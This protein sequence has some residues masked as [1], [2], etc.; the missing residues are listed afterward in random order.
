MEFRNSCSKFVPADARRGEMQSTKSETNDQ[1]QKDNAQNSAN[2]GR[3][4]FEH[5][6]FS[7]GCLF[8][9]S[10][11]VLRVS[12]TLVAGIVTRKPDMPPVAL[13]LFPP[14]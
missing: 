14:C 10:C 9:I 11:F 13:P 6:N 4:R 12:A 3:V 7:F 8:R 1:I 5:L 2:H